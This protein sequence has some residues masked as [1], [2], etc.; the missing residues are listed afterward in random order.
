MQPANKK[1]ATKRTD[2]QSERANSEQPDKGD[3]I[4]AETQIVPENTD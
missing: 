1:I 3:E 4:Q 2:K